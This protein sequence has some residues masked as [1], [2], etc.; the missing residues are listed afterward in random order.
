MSVMTAA[1][2]PTPEPWTML[3]PVPPVEPTAKRALPP[4]S[5]S[6]KIGP[7]SAAFGIAGSSVGSVAPV[8]ICAQSRSSSQPADAPAWAI[9]VSR[10]L[11]WSSVTSC[12]RAATR[13]P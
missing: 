12:S 11:T 13:R 5:V 6:E 2:D 8:T 4:P 3:P 10:Y 9:D 1:T 7:P